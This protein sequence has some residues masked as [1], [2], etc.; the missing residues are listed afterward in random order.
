MFLSLFFT[1]CLFQSLV[2]YRV[3]VLVFDI[4]SSLLG[5]F[6]FFNNG[7]IHMF[8]YM[9]AIFAYW[10]ITAISFHPVSVSLKMEFSLVLCSL[11]NTSPP[12]ANWLSL[13]LGFFPSSAAV[14]PQTCSC[15][16]NTGQK[17][18][19]MHLGDSGL[20]QFKLKK[21]KNYLYNALQHTF[22]YTLFS[23]KWL[24]SG[25]WLTV[26]GSWWWKGSSHV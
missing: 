21:G 22:D 26:I 6:S 5:V 8:Q 3:S 18:Q 2:H 1:V 17:V 13:S 23:F 15:K 7:P 16:T 9:I 4:S 11:L 24:C 10:L 20:L 14:S 19:V 12:P 25:W